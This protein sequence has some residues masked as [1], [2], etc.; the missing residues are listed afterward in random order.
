MGIPNQEQVKQA[1]FQSWSLSSSSKWKVDNPALGQCGVTALV[2]QYF[3]GGDI[4]KTWVVKPGIAELWHY[5]N[6]IDNKPV[7]FTI[8]Q[9]DEP[10]NYDNIPSN[11]D[12]AFEDTNSSQYEYLQTS[13]EKIL[14]D[15]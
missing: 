15:A 1:L 4:V 14:R 9:F 2:A 10:I 7:D 6:L 11:R 3:L 13:V 5:Y 12:E 8:S